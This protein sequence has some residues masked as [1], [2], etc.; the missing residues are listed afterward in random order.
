MDEATANIDYET[1]STIQLA[2]DKFFRNS[3][4]I[5]IAHRI[6]TILN[7]DKVLVLEKGNV[8][9]FDSPKNL[10]SKKDSLFYS[11]VNISINKKE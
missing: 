4:V 3:T 9:E 5:T 1:E 2:I 11:L 10:L 8:I 6:K 7:Y